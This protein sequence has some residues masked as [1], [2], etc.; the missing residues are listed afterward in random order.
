MLN[1]FSFG[2]YAKI[3]DKMTADLNAYGILKDE[4][5]E[6]K[7][8]RAEFSA[9]IVRL[10][11]IDTSSYPIEKSPFVDVNEDDWF[12]N[13]INIMKS[14]KISTDITARNFDRLKM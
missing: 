1:V 3:T 6:D 5:F 14:I 9:M 8:T 10:L 2:T 13:E 11:K 4:R 12:Y 7:I